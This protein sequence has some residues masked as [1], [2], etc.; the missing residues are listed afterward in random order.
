MHGVMAPHDT[1]G[2]CDATLINFGYG[3]MTY[4]PENVD[5]Y[6]LEQ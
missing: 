3:R 6:V 5:A 4:D 2:L 1:N